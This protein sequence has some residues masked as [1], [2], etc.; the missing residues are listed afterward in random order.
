MNYPLEKYKY[1]TWTKP[2][3]TKQVI[4]VSSYCGRTVKGYANCNPDDEFS[5][6]KGKEL[7]AAR[8]NLKVAEKRLNR[9]RSK[10][11]KAFNEVTEKAVFLEKMNHYVTDSSIAL[12]GAEMELENLLKNL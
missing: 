1:Y 12:E 2:N 8:C 6:E 4:A 11:V 9:A 5:L 10:Q 3:G 7:A